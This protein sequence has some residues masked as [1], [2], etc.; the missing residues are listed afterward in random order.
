MT[1]FGKTIVGIILVLI[2]GFGYYFYN[3]SE[4]T[5][6]VAKENIPVTTEPVGKK[7]AFSQLIKEKGTYRCTVNQYVGDV[8]SKGVV[9]MSNGL[10]RGEFGTDITNQHIDTTIIVRDGYS[11]IWTSQASTTGFK[12]KLSET[13]A[14]SSG[15]TMEKYAWN[16]DQIRD[17]NC[18]AW[19]IEESK[20][21]ITYYN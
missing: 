9:Y 20:I 14:T 5:S 1:L 11:Y 12:S 10:L 7:M 3:G 4:N 18:E 6:N 2:G 17:Y 21:Y 16:A 8:E 19:A 13:R 15:T